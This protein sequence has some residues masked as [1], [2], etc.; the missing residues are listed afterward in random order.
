[1][2]NLPIGLNKPLALSWGQHFQISH[3]YKSVLGMVPCLQEKNTGENQQFLL[4]PHSQ[5]D[6][7]FLCSTFAF[8]LQALPLQHWQIPDISVIH[9]S[10]ASLSLH[11]LIHSESLPRFSLSLIFFF[12]FL[13][14]PMLGEFSSLLQTIQE[15]RDFHENRNIL[16]PFPFQYNLWQYEI[17]YVLT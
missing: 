3:T 6:S 4:S 1:M 17:A 14:K 8:L 12:F 11:S 10:R 13:V 5:L 15:E 16:K 9:L 7:S 2:F